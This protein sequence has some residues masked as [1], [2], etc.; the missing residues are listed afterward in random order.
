MYI[1]TVMI[2]FNHTWPIVAG[3]FM[4]FT[5]ICG[6]IISC[7]TARKLKRVLKVIKR[8][9]TNNDPEFIR[10][11]F[12]EFDLDQSGTIDTRELISLCKSLGAELTRDQAEAAIKMLDKSGD[13]FVSLEEFTAWWS[14]PQG[15]ISLA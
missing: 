10:K 2:S 1:G 6:M 5:A 11:K 12:D 14:S 13:G 3:S 9:Q 4:I 8:G 7:V 15:M